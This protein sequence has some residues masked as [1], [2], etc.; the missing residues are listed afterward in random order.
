M[1][2]P[3]WVLLLHLK[4]LVSFNFFD[5]HTGCSIHQIQ[6]FF[7]ELISDIIHILEKDSLSDLLRK[8]DLDSLINNELETLNNYSYGNDTLFPNDGS[9]NIVEKLIKLF[10]KLHSNTNWKRNFTEHVDTLPPKYCQT[11]RLYVS[12]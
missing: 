5:I 2:Q 10:M 11:V 1:H 6:L 3:F 4:K 7:K 9:V 8:D 12:S